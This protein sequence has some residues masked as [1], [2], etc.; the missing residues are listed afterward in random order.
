MRP[1]GLLVCDPGMIR[2]MGG[3]RVSFG[4][5]HGLPQDN[6]HVRSG[7]K[8]WGDCVPFVPYGFCIPCSWPSR[9]HTSSCSRGVVHAPLTNDYLSPELL[10]KLRPDGLYLLF[11][12]WVGW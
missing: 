10:S 7:D 8:I 9:S 12:G 4:P 2:A 5:L 6:R 3:P 11:L 1:I